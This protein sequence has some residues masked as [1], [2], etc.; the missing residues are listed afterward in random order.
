MISPPPPPVPAAIVA[1]VADSLASYRWSRR[2]LLLFA[3]SPTD[4][5]LLA[6]QADLKAHAAGLSERD[7]IVIVSADSA[8]RRDVR[9]PEGFAVVLV[10]KDGGVK[11]RRSSPIPFADLA[12]TVDA[13]PMRRDEMRRQQ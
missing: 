13:M 8:L 10:G 6:Q 2:V 12:A 7:M 3:D 9:A 4:P 1:T 5:R 11:L